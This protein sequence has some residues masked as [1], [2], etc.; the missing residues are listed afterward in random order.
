M[1]VFIDTSVFI[2][3]F[4]KKDVSNKEAIEK[5]NFYKKQNAIFLTSF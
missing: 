5:F 4:L 2:A 1:K 3:Y